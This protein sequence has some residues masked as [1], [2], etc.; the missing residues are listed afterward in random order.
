MYR[1]Q[2]M[3]V[4]AHMHACSRASECRR[5][6]I[7]GLL[8]QMLLRVMMNHKTVLNP[9]GDACVSE[10]ECDSVCA[11]STASDPA[12]HRHVGFR[13][14]FPVMYA[15]ESILNM[16]CVVTRQ[17]KMA[18]QGSL[19]A[20]HCC[21]ILKTQHSYNAQGSGSII[22]HKGATDIKGSRVQIC[23]ALFMAA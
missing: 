8:T 13:V 15:F 22:R 18:F 16:T 9:A 1:S 21:T 23:E 14:L 7:F 5:A 4:A 10:A 20:S 17:Y 11:F 19:L 2:T 6:L 12:V 3:T